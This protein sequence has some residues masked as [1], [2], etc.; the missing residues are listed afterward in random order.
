MRDQLHTKLHALLKLI[1]RETPQNAQQFYNYYTKQKA[2][3]PALKKKC[4]RAAVVATFLN[5]TKFAENTSQ[6]VPYILYHNI[7]KICVIVVNVVVP[8][9]Y[10]CKKNKHVKGLISNFLELNGRGGGRS[11]IQHKLYR[12]KFSALVVLRGVLRSRRTKQD[13]KLN[14]T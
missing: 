10:I 7:V 11:Q 9:V 3:F 14:E 2:A 4:L 12:T 13:T 8:R 1:Y 5:Y 6:V